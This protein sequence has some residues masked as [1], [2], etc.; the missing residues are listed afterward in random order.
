MG[1][2]GPIHLNLKDSVSIG[3]RN[4]ASYPL[5]V[6]C[7]HQR[8]NASGEDRSANTNGWTCES[9]GCESRV[10]GHQEEGQSVENLKAGLQSQ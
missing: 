4:N 1:V 8:H 6:F 5:P 9:M 3:R 2:M 7:E 10:E